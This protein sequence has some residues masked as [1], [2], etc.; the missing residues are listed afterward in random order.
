MIESIG[1]KQVKARADGED[2]VLEWTDPVTRRTDD[3]L[4]TPEDAI[5]LAEE[6]VKEAKK[7]KKG[8]TS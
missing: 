1:G 5:A 2:I 4:L 6:L 3:M 7:A 8:T